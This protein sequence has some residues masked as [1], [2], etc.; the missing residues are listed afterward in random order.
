MINPIAYNIRRLK[1]LHNITSRQLA[2]KLGLSK[3]TV[4]SYAIGRLTPKPNTLQKIAEVFGV[5]VEELTKPPEE[6]LRSSYKDYVESTNQLKAV[7][8]KLMTNPGNKAILKEIESIQKEVESK[9]AFFNN[10]VSEIIPVK[11]VPLYENAVQAGNPLE[12]CSENIV[13]WQP[14]PQSMDV[15]CAVKGMVNSLAEAGI[16]EG[17]VLLVKQTN[18]ANQGDLIIAASDNG[19]TV[20]YLVKNEDTYLLRPANSKYKDITWQNE[21]ARIVGV[22]KGILKVS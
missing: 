3:D 4:D 16:S 13:S 1:K 15:D 14:V 9:R 7:F 2:K 22:V 10:L 21:N 18:V 6:T 19:Y 17:D 8:D 12:L 5:P 20:K 11:Y